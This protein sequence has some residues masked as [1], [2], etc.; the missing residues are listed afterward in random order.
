MEKNSE[1]MI[2]WIVSYI[3]RDRMGGMAKEGQRRGKEWQG[4]RRARKGTAQLSYTDSSMADAPAFA[5]AP[6]RAS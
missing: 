2:N 4:G 3:G 6:T 1:R 5:A